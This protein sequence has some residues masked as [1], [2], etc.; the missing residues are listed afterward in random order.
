M[1]S[2]K[3]IES[4]AHCEAMGTETES[5]SE[6]EQEDQ[7]VALHDVTS[8][9]NSLKKTFTLRQKDY[10]SIM[11]NPAALLPS[12]EHTFNSNWPESPN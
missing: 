7:T 8:K 4:G 11:A 1:T 5:W 12:H 9:N 6:E 2:S 3:G 10:S